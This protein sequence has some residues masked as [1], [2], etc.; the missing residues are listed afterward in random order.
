MLLCNRSHASA[1]AEL[2]RATSLGVNQQFDTFV[3]LL[4]LVLLLSLERGALGSAV[5]AGGVKMK[6]LAIWFCGNRSMVK[7]YQRT[8]SHICRSAGG[9][10]RGP[11][12][13][14]A[15]SDG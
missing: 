3:L 7:E 1:K 4:L 9:G 12:R 5:I 13:L 14:L 2:T 10:H 15:V 11:Q 8:G 6:L